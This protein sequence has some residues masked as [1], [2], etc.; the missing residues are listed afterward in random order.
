MMH[1]TNGERR[2]TEKLPKF[3]CRDVFW[4]SRI[5]EGSADDRYALP[6]NCTYLQGM[7]QNIQRSCF[8]IES[9]HGEYFPFTLLA[10]I[11]IPILAI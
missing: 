11:R 8:D 4:S 6:W 2:D 9:S 3:L 1:L 5:E 7:Q 10:Q